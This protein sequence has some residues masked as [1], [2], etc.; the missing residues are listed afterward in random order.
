MLDILTGDDFK[1]L[2]NEAFEVSYDESAVTLTLSAVDVMDERYSRPGARFSF[3]LTFSG[4]LEPLLP[5]STHR[6]SNKVLG[7]LEMFTV[8]LGPEDGRMRY[9]VVFT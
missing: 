6:F 3:S 5:Q 8:P 7:D 2:L 1:P 9:E 4:P